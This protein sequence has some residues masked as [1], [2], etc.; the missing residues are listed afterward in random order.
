[1]CLVDRKQEV[2]VKD[3]CHRWYNNGQKAIHL[4]Y[5]GQGHMVNES[6]DVRTLRSVHAKNKASLDH[7]QF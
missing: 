5:K 2:Y 4:Y 7:I 3:W 1:M 6:G